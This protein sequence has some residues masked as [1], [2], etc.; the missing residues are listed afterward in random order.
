MGT[1]PSCDHVIN[2]TI[3]KRPCLDD[4]KVCQEEVDKREYYDLRY[5]QNEDGYTVCR[6][7]RGHLGCQAIYKIDLFFRVYM[8]FFSLAE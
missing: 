6:V 4:F 8:V 7:C 5:Q 2:G 3:V 1:Y